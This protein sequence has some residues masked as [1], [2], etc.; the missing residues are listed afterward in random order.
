MSNTVNSCALFVLQLMNDRIC[1][2]TYTIYLIHVLQSATAAAIQL[3]DELAVG[4]R[5]VYIPTAGTASFTD[6]LHYYVKTAGTTSSSSS[7]SDRSAADAVL[8][9]TVA[10]HAQQPALGWGTRD[11]VL[12]DYSIADS[13]AY[14]N[15]AHPDTLMA[16][17]YVTADASAAQAGFASS[18]TGTR[19]TVTLASKQ[20]LTV[21]SY[22]SEQGVEASALTF[23]GELSAV[24]A[25]MTA[26]TL[27]SGS[28][29]SSSSS[30]P[31]SELHTLTI[32]ACAQNELSSAAERANASCAADSAAA[33][34]VSLGYRWSTVPVVTALAPALAPVRGG[35]MLSVRGSNIGSGAALLEHAYNC[36]W[37]GADSGLWTA[38]AVRRS[39]GL[40]LCPIPAVPRRAA[41]SFHL[42]AVSGDYR[43]NSL[44]FGYYWEPAVAGLQPAF[45]PLTG[46]TR[47][48]V[49]G[50]GFT[51][52]AQLSCLIGDT[53]VAAEFLS[54]SSI[55]C[56]TPPAAAA[57][58]TA[59]AAAA[60]SLRV[61]LNGVHWSQEALYYQYQ[62]A[63]VAIWLSPRSGSAN[64]CV[65]VNGLNFVDALSLSC[66]FGAQASDAVYVSSSAVQ[67]AVPPQS[68]ATGDAPVVT[69]TFN[70]V[71]YAASEL[72]Y[73]YVAAPKVT[74]VLPTSGPAAG[75]TVL[76]VVGNGFSSADTSLQCYFKLLN[77]AA[78]PLV[79]AAAAKITSDQSVTCIT[80]AAAAVH[81]NALLT[82]AA[83]TTTVAELDWESYSTVLY[84]FHEPVTVVSAVPRS[85][86]AAAGGML[87]VLGSGFLASSTQL[88]CKLVTADNS[89]HVTAAVLLS[90]GV[91][92]C[93][94]PAQL[95]T[96]D[97]Q[98]FVSNNLADWSDSYAVVALHLPVTALAVTP[99]AGLAT[100]GTA[101][102]IQLSSAVSSGALAQ[103]RFGDQQQRLIAATVSGDVVT[104]NTPPVAATAAAAAVAGVTAV[105]VT[106]VLDG[107]TL[108]DAPLQYSYYAAPAVVA[109]AP[110]SGVWSGSTQVSFQGR[111]FATA[112]T[113]AAGSVKCLFGELEV[114]AVIAS[115][116][117]VLCRAPPSA[118][119]NS[120]SS[121]YSTV[122]VPLALSFNGGADYSTVDA[123]YTY[124]PAAVA[125]GVS[126]QLLPLQGGVVTISGN[127][128]VDTSAL[129]CVLEPAAGGARVNVAATLTSATTA[130]CT[131]P[132]AATAG[133]M[134]LY[135][136]NNGQDV[137]AGAAD[138]AVLYAEPPA[139]VSVQ[140]AAGP[141]SGGTA[142]TVAY[143]AATAAAVMQYWT[144]VHCRFGA[145]VVPGVL[146][147]ADS[148]VLCYSVPRVATAV[149]QAA[150]SVNGRD[151]GAAADFAYTQ[152]PV[153]NAVQPQHV[154][155]AAVAAGTAVVEV[156]GQY[157]T[158]TTTP[159]TTICRFGN[160][161]VTADVV[162]PGLIRCTVPAA[163]VS[164]SSSSS[165][166][167]T[168]ST[169][170]ADYSR[171]SYSSLLHVVPAA[172]VS[173]QLVPQSGP[174]SGGTAVLIGA[175]ELDASQQYR[176]VFK[177]LNSA[178]TT[179]VAATVD[180]DVLST[181]VLRCVTPAVSNAAPATVTIESVSASGSSSVIEEDSSSAALE[182]VFTEQTE[183]VKL[184]P[185]HGTAAGG[186]AVKLTLAHSIEAIS[187]TLLMCKFGDVLS[188]A[189]L[190]DD[191]TVA[192]CHSPVMTA[193]TTVAVELS[194][195]SVDYS[196]S[197]QIFSYTAP[198]TVTDVSPRSGP[199]TGGTMVYVTGT[200][201]NA[202]TATLQCR[203]GSGATV[204]LVAAVYVSDGVCVC[205]SP[206]VAAA[207]SV[208]IALTTNEQD[209]SSAEQHFQ[210]TAAAVITSVTPLTGP[211]SGGTV[212]Y[213]SGSGFNTATATAAGALITCQFGDDS[214]SSSRVPAT[215]LS[216]D[217]LAC[218][219]P[220]RRPG[221]V[222]LLISTNGQQYVR[223]SSDYTYHVSVQ[224]RAVEPTVG[225]ARGGTVVTVTGSGFAD[226]ADLSCEVGWRRA[227]AVY[228]SSTELSCVVPPAAT[229][230]AATTAAAVRVSNNGVD[231]APESSRSSSSSGA[232]FT[233]VGAVTA[234][235]VTP[236]SGS[237]AGGTV[238][239]IT[240]IG[241]T[242]VATTQ[243]VIGDTVVAAVAAADSDDALLCA[244]P[245]VSSAGTVA[246]GLT[247]NG[248]ADV[249][250][251]GLVFSYL[252]EVMLSSLL[253][254]AGCENGGTQL[255]ILGSGFV[256]DSQLACSFEHSSAVTTLD[257]V[258]AAAAAVIVVPA[259]Y[260]S[261]SVLQCS[262]PRL[263]LGPA[264]V[265]VTLNGVDWSE[266]ALTYRY[267]PSVSV[268][269]V[270]PRSGSAL[271]GTAV[272]VSGTGF[273]SAASSLFYCRFGS[274]LVPADSVQQHGT[275]AVCRAP[276][277][278]AGT[279]VSVDITNNGADF[280]S[281]GLTYSYSAPVV[282]TAV[283]PRSGPLSGGTVVTVTAADNGFRGLTAVSCK[284]DGVQIVPGAV[285]A[286]SGACICVAPA[287][288]QRGAVVLTVSSNGQDYSSAAWQFVYTS[289]VVLSSLQLLTGPETGGTVLHVYGSG[290]TEAASAAAA[291]PQCQF[292][293][294]DSGAAAVRTAGTVISD[295]VLACTTPA[296]KPEA[297][298]VSI[299][300]NGQQ[301][302]A[303][304]GSFAYQASAQI[305]ALQPARGP[306]YGGTVVTVVG[307]NFVN[308]TDFSCDVG[309]R[310][311][312]AVYIDR[313]TAQCTVPAA[314]A[315]TASAVTIE[316]SNNGIDYTQHGA[317]YQYVS[318]PTVRAVA[319][320]NG[321]T[322]GGTVLTVTLSGDSSSSSSELQCVIGE[323]VVPAQSHTAN[324][325]QCATPARA[326]AGVVTVELTV[327]DGADVTTEGMTY[328]YLD[329]AVV[330]A[331]SPA[332]GSEHG[333]Y[334][335]VISGSGFHDSAELLCRFGS[336]ESAATVQAVYVSESLLSC[337]VPPA[338]PGAAAVAVSNNGGAD[339]S[340][341]AAA[342]AAVRFKYLPS[343]ELAAVTPSAGPPGTLVTVTGTGIVPSDGRLW[344]CLFGSTR[345]TAVAASSSEGSL[346]CI[347][348]ASAA[349]TVQVRVT[350]TD[351]GDTPLE[352]AELALTEAPHK[353]GLLTYVY[354]DVAWV[355]SVVPGYVPVT[356]NT[357]LTVR[358]AN[359]ANTTAL[360][361]SFT[362]AHSDAAA[363]VTS[364][365]QWLSSTAVRCTAPA[366]EAFFT[367]A[368][369]VVAAAAVH[370]PFAVKLTVTV[371]GVGPSADV[372][373]SGGA[374]SL[375]YF[376]TA[377]TTAVVPASGS[378]LGGTVV[379]VAG[380]SFAQ[381]PELVCRFGE[382]TAVPAQWISNTSVTCVTPAA[383]P[384]A[385][386]LQVVV[387]NNGVDFDAAAANATYSY[388]PAVVVH[389]FAPTAGRLTGGT[390][391]T[392]A[393]AGVLRS[394][395]VLCQFGTTTV[396]GAVINSTAATTGT[397]ADSNTD[398]V[399]QCRAP[400]AVAAR[401]VALRISV[402]NG[403]DWSSSSSS[404]GAAKAQL[405]SYYAAPTVQQLQ[406]SVGT[407]AGGTAV[408]V[409]GTN[410][411]LAEAVKSPVLCQFG[412]AVATA[413]VSVSAT[414]VVCTAP[415]AA[416]IL[417]ATTVGVRVS[418]DGGDSYT[419]P[420]MA[421]AYLDSAEVRS[422]LIFM[423]TQCCL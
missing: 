417:H 419:E 148:T 88:H 338:A 109:V 221:A 156:I 326:A 239:R 302:A 210:Y 391:V 300:F 4:T 222:P 177:Y 354:T 46:G 316:L 343:I 301:F 81:G 347:S 166:H 42:A 331:I 137:A 131:L 206:A 10:A 335:A 318:M 240:G 190:T 402:N 96:G 383:A 24:E 176:C 292:S 414:E 85:L 267:T 115:A 350:A 415:P 192:V 384:A 126:P 307:A 247:V 375:L 254:A 352:A 26:L 317:V 306:V 189:E 287:S 23:Y 123:A 86:D 183:V 255:L 141:V 59:L 41:V 231:F 198:V 122:T 140:P 207:A 264:A 99:A 66:K 53:V 77:S 283:Q 50:S 212:V 345:S 162:H 72:T 223:A 129:T 15:A 160:T 117:A 175:S 43:S 249:T 362:A 372:G 154:I 102:A 185:T 203:F 168:V 256:R 49:L 38:A 389:S 132:A 181:S 33:R 214:S 119:G 333:G 257:E 322:T 60:V 124:T 34:S 18:S 253:P 209:Y 217:L 71:D 423:L 224:V 319:P 104:C 40:L 27:R 165:V 138:V 36:V 226:S 355:D 232:V 324:S 225:P 5:L 259:V 133:S 364:E 113:A 70:G 48:V 67:C 6:T 342:A 266:A 11:I 194:S 411:L 233:Y 313:G 106:V 310:R 407:A 108:G 377:T 299:S 278:P 12:E 52:S 19:S 365:V 379:T 92:Q 330:T 285:D 62:P 361:C 263:P 75:G 161:D 213:I 332:S 273:S 353:A 151:F 376:A 103:C 159:S 341:A 143:D 149:V 114:T 401:A 20:G 22:G 325:V 388:R 227:A 73:S 284:F 187:S 90:E 89:E 282:V 182:F 191:D 196:S 370:V 145:T 386:A 208:S 93:A 328:A 216:S 412:S 349:G 98:L 327:N 378:E 305:H 120:S 246:V 87:V 394:D 344:S 276:P 272:T 303:V 346:S 421:F 199:L 357:T 128:F 118:A 164:S 366:A 197:K 76:T 127:G 163:A 291:Q 110:Q 63:P 125:S 371:N 337:T 382:L 16:S 147:L 281:S 152:L 31:G 39:E 94:V 237:V 308:S 359:F 275:T 157:F 385:A 188:T 61:S 297:V 91:L 136:S 293:S 244:T 360:A 74:G 29:R 135:V 1:T 234:Q 174:L 170:G 418:V 321:P 65:T 290:F 410:F 95:P 180:A 304:A 373:G 406:P 229:S 144:D 260:V 205:L 329:P 242:S 215:V 262:T 369:A 44:S 314:A 398:V 193:G 155:A 84:L 311:A 204:A 47:V 268:S 422:Q 294:T 8:S 184:S 397:A 69:V 399:V 296:H 37:G 21:R 173:S 100:G 142:V 158:S 134:L 286:L 78:E 32:A 80:P 334:T 58:A 298:A 413:A 404:S 30:A 116:T 261:E 228:V 250:T 336:G 271:G 387:S 367:A 202:A 312:A 171:L 396:A 236:S 107:R 235:S 28:S 56:T 348:P 7:S 230:S 150:L 13:D 101:V 400:A 201:F 55:A 167:V 153:V 351:A 200:G 17:L 169:N 211:E 380:T 409:I 146:S 68:S 238:L 45:G 405:F 274:V 258:A 139:V 82:I 35:G 289:D 270:W 279:V 374:A 363:V 219:A 83:T 393:A 408:T 251:T 51:A 186:T 392:V 339:Y 178:S 243:C 79:L 172:A 358:G 245:A 121:S 111:N 340:T 3:G 130:Q 248:G 218:T 105:N 295:S 220:Q 54:D 57:A 315:L 395:A 269:A 288:V 403:G 420:P 280:S 179:E 277:M 252:P 64:G 241:L 390:L 25:A 323:T 320:H 195:N 2:C 309:G 14:E 416:S 381:S 356:G 265:R 97:A 9:I 112:A 368:A